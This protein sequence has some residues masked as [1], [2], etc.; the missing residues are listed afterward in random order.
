MLWLPN[1]CMLIGV[2]QEESEWIT[3]FEQKVSAYIHKQKEADN[4]ATSVGI[5]GWFIIMVIGI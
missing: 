5:I 1:G 2:L 3:V 4:L